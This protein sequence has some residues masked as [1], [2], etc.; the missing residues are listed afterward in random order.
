MVEDFWD[1][2]SIKERWEYLYQ[3][4]KKT[5]GLNLKDKPVFLIT[6]W[7][8]AEGSVMGLDSKVRVFEANSNYHKR[9]Y[10]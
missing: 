1:K 8:I 2:I 5:T 4:V 10:N 6:Y 3:N 7:N 9:Q